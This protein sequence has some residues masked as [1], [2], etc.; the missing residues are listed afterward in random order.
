MYKKRKYSAAK[1]RIK[2]KK[3]VLVTDTNQLVA[4]RIVTPQWLNF[5]KCSDTILLKMCLEKLLS[6]WKETLQSAHE[7]ISGQHHFQNHSDHPHWE[8]QHQDG[9]L[10]EAAE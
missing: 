2:K 1:S 10:P 7:K 3:K 5:T 4:T 8:P 9:G 6:H